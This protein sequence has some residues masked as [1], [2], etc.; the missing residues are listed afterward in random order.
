MS[1]LEKAKEKA[2]EN[3]ELSSFW[4]KYKKDPQMTPSINIRSPS[5]YIYLSFHSITPSL[6]HPGPIKAGSYAHATVNY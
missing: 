2:M 1:P 6:C 5:S 3:G 4:S